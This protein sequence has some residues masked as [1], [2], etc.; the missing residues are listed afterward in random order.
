MKA[1]APGVKTFN[2]APTNRRRP[3]SQ[4]WGAILIGFLAHFFCCAAE[5][6]ITAGS[7]NEGSATSLLS[8][9]SANAPAHL[10]FAD[11]QNSFLK[12]E[13]RVVSRSDDSTEFARAIVNALIKGSQRGLI[14]TIPAGTELNAIYIAPDNVCYVDFSEAVKKNHPGGSNSEMLTIFSVVNSL[15]L[16]VSEIKRVK[17]LIQ[18]HEAPTLAGHIALQ[19]PF[20]AHMLMIR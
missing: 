12:S 9:P 19:V 8:P 11:R 16:N 10:Y 6:E 3:S 7:S 15:I 13:Q 1:I 20:K 5:A 18:G 4:I 2:M 17:I 14:R